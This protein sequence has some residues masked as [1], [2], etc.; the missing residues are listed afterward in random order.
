MCTFH[1]QNVNLC[2]EEN[3][4]F[5]EISREAEIKLY[6]LRNSMNEMIF[7]IE[8][9]FIFGF[10]KRYMKNVDYCWYFLHGIAKYFIIIYELWVISANFNHKHC[11]CV[12]NKQMQMT[13]SLETFIPYQYRWEWRRRR[14][15]LWT[16][17]RYQAKN[18]LNFSNCINCS[19]KSVAFQLKQI[20][21]VNWLL[22][23]LSFFFAF[24]FNEFF[25]KWYLIF[26]LRFSSVSLILL[27]LFFV[28]CLSYQYIKFV[29]R[30]MRTIN[31]CS[32]FVIE[33]KENLVCQ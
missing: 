31:L 12:I 6:K 9:V 21:I 14:R 5:F 15:K 16:K 7:C 1:D 17:R 33:G 19:I 4:F 3:F 30:T 29:R 10:I 20:F 11:L 28:F 27:S 26:L 18:V 22:C 24:L 25:F 13:K 32:S 2:I 23:H 8:L